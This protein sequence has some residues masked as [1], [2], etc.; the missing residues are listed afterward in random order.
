VRLVRFVEDIVVCSVV[1]LFNEKD[2]VF[3]EVVMKLQ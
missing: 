3:T 2:V 1:E